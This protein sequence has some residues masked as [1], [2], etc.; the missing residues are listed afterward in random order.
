MPLMRSGSAKSTLST[1][2]RRATRYQKYLTL[3]SVFLIITQTIVI[4]T[5]V[6]LMRF[7]FLDNLYFW[8]EYFRVLP[9]FM[10]VLGIYNFLVAIY[11][12]GIANME[13][14]A[15]LGIFAGVLAVGFI[16]QLGAVFVAWQVRTEIVV[17]NIGSAN[18][19][20]VLRYYGIDTQITTSWDSMQQ[21][22]RCCGG[23]NWLSGYLEYANTPMG[24]D[25][26][27]VPDSCC[28]TETEGC[29]YNIFSQSLQQIRNVIF[30]DGCLTVLQLLLDEDVVPIM[31]AYAAIGILI[32]LA[33]LVALV[34]SCAFMAQISRKR[35]REEMVWS[36]VRT[37]DHEDMP[38]MANSSNNFNTDQQHQQ[39]RA[40]HRSH[41][42]ITNE[43]E[44]MC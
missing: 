39:H 34:L 21:R 5:A 11:G 28:R 17:A 9:I 38:D 3:V 6:V 13:H 16:A 29:G 44:T 32:A 33:K 8:S 36:A 15:L 37:N 7:Y 31:A 20:E 41:G 27:S 12:F 42:S 19:V 4:F 18:T 40:H 26:N 30:V 25:H 24:K 14:R 35:Q 1:I 43:Q 23:T 22:L 10:I 2:Q